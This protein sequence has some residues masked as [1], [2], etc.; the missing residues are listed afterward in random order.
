[1]KKKWKNTKT[2][3]TE[4]VF[5]TILHDNLKYALHS[6]VYTKL[7]KTVQKSHLSK[8]RVENEWTMVNAKTD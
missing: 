5:Y 4:I 8:T 2:A 7:E 3:R 1:M 6:I